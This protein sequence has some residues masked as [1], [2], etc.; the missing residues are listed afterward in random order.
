MQ[1]P[2][3][4][5]SKMMTAMTILLTDIDN[6]HNGQHD[7]AT[8]DTTTSDT[9]VD[10]GEGGQS[11]LCCFL[12]PAGC[13]HH[14]CLCIATTQQDDDSNGSKNNADNSKGEGG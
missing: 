9:N 14:C 13:H 8:S 5:N 7:A 4:K 11:F 10:Y 6:N 1:P 2:L 12:M 3:E